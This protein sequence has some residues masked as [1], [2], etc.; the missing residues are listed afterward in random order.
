VVKIL[1]NWPSKRLLQEQGMR[2][3]SALHL[4]P[5]SCLFP[6]KPS[7]LIGKK[8]KSLFHSFILLT[9]DEKQHF[10]FI[11]Y[12]C[13]LICVH[14]LLFCNVHFPNGLGCFKRFC[15]ILQNIAPYQAYL[16]IFFQDHFLIFV[17]FLLQVFPKIL[18]G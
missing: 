6:W 10:S 9:V 11:H 13:C 3:P 17:V 12:A 1:T 7:N 2:V 4:G 18:F 5:L 16:Q 8:I 14:E 15:Y